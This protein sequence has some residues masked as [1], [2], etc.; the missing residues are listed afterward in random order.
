MNNVFRVVIVGAGFAGIGIAMQ[1]QRAGWG[2]FRI[3]EKGADVGGTW[4]ENSYPGAACDIPSHLYSYSFEP[5][6]DWSSQFSPQPEIHGYLQRCARKHGLYD[7]IWFNCE[8]AEARF[9]ESISRWCITTVSGE[10][11]QAEYL[12]A[13]TGQLNKPAYP[14]VPGIKSFRGPSFHSACWDHQA[15]LAGKRVAVVGNGASAIQLV[16]AVAEQV[17]ELTL[18]QR[19]A[20]WI[21]PRLARDY[22]NAWRSRFRRRPWLRWLY[23]AKLFLERDL[24]FNRIQRQGSMNRKLAAQARGYLAAVIDDTEL[25][26]KLTP[27][28]P[29]GCKRVLISD[30]Y[31]P[32]L[33]RA[34]VRVNDKGVKA[35]TADG[36]VDGSGRKTEVDAII[37]ATG[38]QSHDF[39][40]PIAVYGENGRALKEEW[41]D[42]ARAYMGMAVAGFPNLFVLYGPN[43]NLGHNSIIFMLECQFRYI[44]RC[45]RHCERQGLRRMSVSAAAQQRYDRQLQKGFQGSTWAGNCN[46]WYKASSGRIINN[47][48]GRAW[49]YW[50]LTRKPRYRDYQFQ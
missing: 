25:R 17:A 32:A 9:D 47:W 1:L 12:V 8:V 2:D 19:S 38:F 48:T 33:R 40:F 34:N 4:R 14:P 13:A 28:Y 31:Y 21:L 20:N 3:L 11:M 42:G 27:D 5:N 22:S 43:T 39:L 45:L 50:W 16:P 44:I 41:R 23:R 49:S 36:V 10:A 18:F 26:L 6:P 7:K 30:D 46:S 29:L 35:V 37:Y 24:R 15:D